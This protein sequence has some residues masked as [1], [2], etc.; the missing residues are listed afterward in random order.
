[1]INSFKDAKLAL[2]V[3]RVLLLV[4]SRLRHVAISY[5]PPNNDTIGLLRTFT[6]AFFALDTTD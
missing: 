6:S 2:S 4:A 3:Y 5:H 1:M